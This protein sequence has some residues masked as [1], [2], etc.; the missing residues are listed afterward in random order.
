MGFG[1]VTVGLNQAAAG[2]ASADSIWNLP[3]RYTMTGTMPASRATSAESVTARRLT[4]VLLPGLDAASRMSRQSD[5]SEL[6]VIGV[7]ATLRA[8]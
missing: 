1:V 3:D 4:T 2:S 7:N 8:M 6:S 5:E